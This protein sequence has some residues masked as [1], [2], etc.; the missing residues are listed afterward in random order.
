MAPIRVLFLCHLNSGRTLMAE[1]YLR[2]LGRG[3]FEAASAGFSSAVPGPLVI[4]VM[5]E[6]NFDLSARPAADVRDLI[7]EH[8]P[9]HYVITTCSP[10]LFG[11][12]P[13]F[14]GEVARQHW[15]FPD[16]ALITGSPEERL[17]AARTIRDDIR[18][19]VIRFV[20]ELTL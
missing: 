1:A 4:E 11:E 16:P 18:A 9:F 8:P 5:R 10:E 2:R 6:A 20:H 13:A 17:A 19:Q 7:R 14:P 15:G 12:V 3:L